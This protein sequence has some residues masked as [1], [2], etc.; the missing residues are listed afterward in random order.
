[1]YYNVHNIITRLTYPLSLCVCRCGERGRQDYRI[2]AGSRARPRHNG[3]QNAPNRPDHR[4]GAGGAPDAAV[5]GVN[6]GLRRSKSE[7]SF[8]CTLVVC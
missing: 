5:V 2:M 1:M 7:L 6:Q 3:R 8:G 4:D